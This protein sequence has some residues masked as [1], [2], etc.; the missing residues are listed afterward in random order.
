MMPAVNLSESNFQR[1]Q[2][3]AV[4]LEDDVNSVL[5]KVLD[6]AESTAPEPGT[7]GG[8]GGLGIA[9][10]F[11]GSIP[12]NLSF[13]TVKLAKVNGEALK[14]SENY[15]NKI[16]FN[17]V[18]GAS[19][20]GATIEDVLKALPINCTKGSKTDN[21]Y[22]YL[23]DVGLSLQGQDSNG[24]WK[25]IHAVATTFGI[26]VEVTFAWQPNPKAFSPNS[27]GVLTA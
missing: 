6:L 1:L 23:D 17:V 19:V 2:K 10:R 18:R 14:P 8:Q 15:W 20:E 7:D 4:P 27:T 5:A 26:A 11:V 24:A 12:P 16:M 25:A 3:F 9:K 13:T 22:Y 21:G